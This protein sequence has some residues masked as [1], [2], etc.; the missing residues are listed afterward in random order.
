[1]TGTVERW[2]VLLF[3]MRS[4]PARHRIALWRELRKAGAVSLGQ[5]AWALPDLPAVRPVL[6][7]VVRPR[8]SRRPMPAG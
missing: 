4:E 3:R 8:A 7:R 5:S 1:V 6:A 2:V